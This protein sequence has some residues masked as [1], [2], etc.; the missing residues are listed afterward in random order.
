MG[1]GTQEHPFNGE[2]ST[3]DIAELGHL[4]GVQRTR[5]E[6]TRAGGNKL[7]EADAVTV[8]GGVHGASI[9]H[10]VRQFLGVTT[11]GEPLLG[12][13]FTAGSYLH[14]NGHAIAIGVE[15]GAELVDSGRTIDGEPNEGD[16]VFNGGETFGINRLNAGATCGCQDAGG[17]GKGSA[18]GFIFF[19]TEVGGPR[20][21]GSCAKVPCTFDISEFDGVG[22]VHGEGPVDGALRELQQVHG[23]GG[24]GL[25][26]DNGVELAIDLEERGEIR[27]G[28]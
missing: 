3:V 28:G 19:T 16:K 24:G 23:R 13:T 5:R 17:K 18:I 26:L 27:V 9:G 25:E 8:I 21:D 1:V 22:A 20:S 6:I 15:G 14:F 11:Q 4:G 2:V 7:E 10:D 12:L